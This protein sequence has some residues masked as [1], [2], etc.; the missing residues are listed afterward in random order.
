MSYTPSE[1]EI[2][3]PI[4]NVLESFEEL[5]KVIRERIRSQEWSQEHIDILHMVHKDLLDLEVKLRRI[6]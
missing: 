5:G 1:E 3:E 6:L 4:K 2:T